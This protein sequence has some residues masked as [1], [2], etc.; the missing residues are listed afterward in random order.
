M[1]R[2][3]RAANPELGGVVSMASHR[4]A[5]ISARKGR[6]VADLIRGLSVGEA[7]LQLER[8]HRPSAAPIFANVLKSA[9]ANAKDQQ[10]IMDTDGLVI[11]EVFVDD[12]PILKRFRP[13]AM[14][15]AATIRKR[16]SHVTIKLYTEA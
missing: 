8:I 2:A 5:K 13:R 9:A 11:G 4:F 14:G 6:Y 10:E 16:M 3:R 7:L 12:G 1:S 15:R